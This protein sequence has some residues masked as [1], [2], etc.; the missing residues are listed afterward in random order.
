[1]TSLKVYRWF[2]GLGIEVNLGWHDYSSRR[3]H[4][5]TSSDQSD[6]VTSAGEGD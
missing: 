5:R 2:N 6:I 1:M 4:P 3:N